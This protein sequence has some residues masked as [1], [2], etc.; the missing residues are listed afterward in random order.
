MW[1]MAHTGTRHTHTHTT[2]TTTTHKYTHRF[3]T[4]RSFCVSCLPLLLCMALSSYQHTCSRT[5]SL[6]TVKSIGKLGSIAIAVNSLAGPAILQ[7]PFQ[8]QQSVRLFVAQQPPH[9]CLALPC[10]AFAY[11]GGCYSRAHP[12]YFC[13]CVIVCV[14]VRGCIWGCAAHWLTLLCFCT[15]NERMDERKHNGHRVS[16][17]PR[18]V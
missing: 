1:R 14:C 4:H 16:F 17:R 7:L 13:V 3:L 6:T 15:M 8:Y 12:F 11:L 18:A 9:P 10:R 5:H 2:T